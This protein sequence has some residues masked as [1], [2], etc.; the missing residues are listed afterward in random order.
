[1]LPNPMKMLGNPTDFQPPSLHCF[2]ENH[3]CYAKCDYWG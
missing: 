2:C 1:M 3:G